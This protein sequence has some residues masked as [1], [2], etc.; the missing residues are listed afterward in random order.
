MYNRVSLLIVCGLIAACSPAE[1][2]SAP[3]EDSR[4]TQHW[5]FMRSDTALD[6]NAATTRNTW[7]IVDLPHTPKLEPL[8][9]DKQFQGDTWY[10][11]NIIPEASWQSKQV[12]L[13]FDAAM[14]TAEIWLND[15]KISHHIGGYLPF[16][17]NLSDK[18]KWN[19][20]NELLV[21]LD[22]RDNPVTGLQTL[23]FNAYGG[24]YR[25]VYLHID[26]DLHITDSLAANNPASG[27]VF[28]TYKEVTPEHALIDIRT[29]VYNA[30]YDPKQFRIVQ[31]LML[32]EKVVTDQGS[33]LLSIEGHSDAQNTIELILPNPLRWS[34]QTPHLYR[35]VTRV[36]EGNSLV[37]EQSTRIG[38]REFKM[39]DGALY[40]NGE[41]VQLRGVNRYQE[42][43]YVGYATSEAA[44]YRDAVKIKS[45]GFDFVFLPHYPQSTA[46]M[47]AADE[48]GLIVINS[49][50]GSQYYS[51]DPAF[52]AYIQQACRDLVRRDRNHPSAL[53]WKCSDNRASTPNEFATLLNNIISEE[54]PGA[55]N[56]N[57]NSD[58]LTEDTSPTMFDHNRGNSP[59]LDTSGIMTINR[60]PKDEYFLYQSQRD[61]TEQSTL[62]SSGPMVHIASDWTPES[63]LS[64]QVFSNGEQVELLLNGKNLGKQDPDQ[65]PKTQHLQHPPFTFKIEKFAPGELKAVAYR[66][67]KI[68]AEETVATPGEASSLRLRV[69]TSGKPPQP[70][71]NDILFVYAQLIDSKGNPVTR[72]NIPITFTL[73][74]NAK[75]I[76]PAQRLTDN[77]TASAL[78]EIGE[79][80]DKLKINA[81]TEGLPPATLKIQ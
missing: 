61:A 65:T 31:R 53:S 58:L 16:T 39:I 5:Q 1:N 21:R 11:K 60:L 32:G 70:G 68:V 73:Q 77:G 52:Q 37:D 69:D 54:Y 80:L 12:S 67:G 7:E 56:L 63:P 42:F 62:F 10:R 35:L 66:N 51:D 48:L 9:V 24:I 17:I 13:E 64:V 44:E 57:A 59:D 6:V 78:I 74:G 43:P 22:N 41:K 55:Q 34:P 33:D 50:P 40:L 75:L 46:F 8:I 4:F 25:P 30:H 72:N 3:V 45:A 38:I 49:A 29:H 14:N 18:L 23:N 15:E 71:V 81:Q 79:S 36:Y 2:P 27:G 20:S 19:T 26:N 76:S 47:N 28:V